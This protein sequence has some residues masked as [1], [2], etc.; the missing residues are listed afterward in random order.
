MYLKFNK[1]EITGAQLK[2][3]AAILELDNVE[4]LEWF[5]N[6]HYEACKYE[7]ECVIENNVELSELVAIKQRDDYEEII[8]EFANNLY[9]AADW[10]WD[11]LYEK[12]ECIVDIDSLIEDI[13]K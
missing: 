1:D 10:Q 12:A 4:D 11:Q 13:Y 3:I 2:A 8:N 9:Y 6:V 5:Y 7:V